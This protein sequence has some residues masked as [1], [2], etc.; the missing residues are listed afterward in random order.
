MRIAI[1]TDRGFVSAHFGRCPSFT[2]A[3]IEDSKVVKK[4]VIDNPGHQ[5]GLIPQLLHEQGAECILCGGIGQR[6][7]GIFNEFG[8]EV[9][10]GVSGN[11]DKAIEEF[12]NGTLK[13]GDSFCKPGSG[14]GYGL[15]KDECDHGSDDGGHKD[16]ENIS[17]EEKIRS[18]GQEENSGD[19]IC[20][21][22][23]SDN[24]DSDVDPRFGR[25]KY[26][27]VVDLDTLEFEAI[28]NSNINA[29]GGAGIQS[30]QFMADKGVKSVLT[31]NVGPNAFQTLK[32]AGIEIITGA[33]GTV[34]E[35]V[36]RYK[37]GGFKSIQ[38]PSVDSHFGM[39]K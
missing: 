21:T 15:D 1:S 5:P 10:A 3:D 22:S 14:K 9:I 33:S 35:A 23:Q 36:E 32:A 6:A 26:F 24:L 30:G 25:C 39:S 7:V 16:S 11:V 38:G 4:N 28:D 29:S 2:I 13:G 20:V 8:I 31:G 17:D 27:I 37:R 12:S 18:A 34:R 19:K